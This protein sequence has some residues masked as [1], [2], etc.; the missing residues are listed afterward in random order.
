VIRQNKSSL[1][2]NNQTKVN[3]RAD[4]LFSE[5]YKTLAQDTDRMFAALLGIEWIAG[6]LFA[7]IFSPRVWKG[8]QSSISPHLIAAIF[9]GAAIAGLPI[10]LVMTQ[11]GEKLTRHAIA[12]AQMAFSALLI[13]M[14][15][16][17]IETHFHVFG[18]LAMLAFYR[19]PEVL[20]TATLTILVDHIARGLVYPQSIFGVTDWTIIRP[21]EHA[22]WV[23][24]EN[25]FL[26]LACKKN[27]AE[28]KSVASHRA[29]SEAY[30][31]TLED[32]RKEEEKHFEESRQAMSQ[33]NQELESTSSLLQS[34]FDAVRPVVYDLSQSGE[35]LS[36]AVTS[37][38]ETTKTQVRAIHER[39][40]E[41]L[42]ITASVQSLRSSSERTVK[43]TQD[44]AGNTERAESLKTRG[45]QSLQKTIGTLDGIRGQIS[46]VNER[47]SELANHR[48]Q[49]TGI[50]ERVEDFADQSNLLALNATIEAA[51]AG[52]AG[53]GFGVVAGEIRHLSERSLE[54]THEIRSV[55]ERIQASVDG[56]INLSAQS[57][58][59]VENGIAEI[60]ASGARIAELTEY[61][62]ESS[63][64]LRS[65]AAS[66]QEQNFEFMRVSGLVQNLESSLRDIGSKIQSFEDVVD[67]LSEVAARVS[68]T[69]R[70]LQEIEGQSAQMHHRYV[71]AG[72]N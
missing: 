31:Q 23:V 42:S 12:F 2:S 58:S 43:M 24:F 21:L 19:D 69:A 10:W 72:S 55:L 38:M 30:A 20:I 39:V 28:M 51:R 49:I 50:T 5:A 27:I 57:N 25:I 34:A 14:T 7:L 41:L 62:R 52:E 64:S 44:I 48:E 40:E 66:V 37:L 54:S 1:T 46:T 11:P 65:I 35:Q 63:A 13:H 70:K 29:Q 4:N 18:S 22:G 47:I 3:E 33:K 67:M 36:G 59:R 45:E 15:G 8:D 6:I 16:G 71:A 53:R 32:T 68:L 9:L 56:A 60:K 26:F 61:I 17:R